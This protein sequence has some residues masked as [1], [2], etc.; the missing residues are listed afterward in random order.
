MGSIHIKS[1]KYLSALNSISQC[2][3][4]YEKYFGERHPD[5]LASLNRFGIALLKV[6]NFSEAFNILKRCLDLSKDVLGD[7]H[8]DYLLNLEAMGIGL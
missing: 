7:R 2:K 1:G 3:Q 4:L 8:P 5:Y 6:G